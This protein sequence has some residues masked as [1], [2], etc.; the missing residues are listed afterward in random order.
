MCTL[1][2]GARSE[3]FDT[4]RSMTV[5]AGVAARGFLSYVRKDNEGY[6]SVVD[7]LKTALESRFHGSTGR[8]LEIFVDRDAIGWGDDWR[9][10]IR[11]SVQAATFFIPV[12]TMRYFQS[13]ACRE[14]LLAFHQ[15]AK[16]LGVEALILP[17]VLDGASKISAD[18]PREEVRLIERLNYRNIHD[19]WL[20]GYDS[21]TWLREISWMVQ[22][23]ES[24]LTSAETTL[25]SREA[26]TAES[27][28]Q[29]KDGDDLA[30]SRVADAEALRSSLEN[31][32]VLTER[33]H[34]AIEDFATAGGQLQQVNTS[35]LSAPQRQAAFVRAAHELGGPAKGLAEVGGEFEKQVLVCDSE[36]RA[37][38]EE[39]RAID[40]DL[41]REQL[42][43]LVGSLRGMSELAN[44]VGQLNQLVQAL[45]FAAI[46][47]ISIRKS[48][49]PAIA[50]VQ[51][52]SNAI[53]T[54]RSWDSI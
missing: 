31:V 8:R 33:V 22:Q 17:L 18:D 47:N 27:A 14:E 23:L 25:S 16:E 9:A 19:A 5:E 1:D 46:T 20:A 43:T 24:K 37:V 39:L 49:Q 13:D 15:Y 51:S 2:P 11:E 26:S 44:V 50:G 7:E 35:G 6:T 4:I 41:A 45:R 10:K 36:L 12:V 40:V 38:A 48:V 3:D 29:V 54:V 21:S 28:T 34:K 52:I 53:D 42:A 30:S 32:T